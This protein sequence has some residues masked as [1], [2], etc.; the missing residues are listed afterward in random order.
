MLNNSS[1]LTRYSYDRF[2][3]NLRHW[4]VIFKKCTE[5]FLTKPVKVA[6]EMLFE[7][8][9][10]QSLFSLVFG[11]P[12]YLQF[13]A[14]PRAACMSCLPSFLFCIV[15]HGFSSK[16]DCLQSSFTINVC[17]NDEMVQDN[18]LAC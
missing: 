10:L 4:K 18:H 1:Q 9:N 14:S 15:S 16:R 12:G 5:V 2:V 13:L 11:H 17:L 7:T 3:E 6:S 8:L